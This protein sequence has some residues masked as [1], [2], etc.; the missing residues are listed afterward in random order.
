MSQ[1][2]D[3][4][5]LT[6]LQPYEDLSYNYTL[7]G[8]Q[9]GK[10]I[11]L[12]LGLDEFGL[13]REAMALKAFKGYGAISVIDHQKNAL[14]LQRAIPGTS[15]KGNPNA[16]EIACNVIKRLNKAPI[17]IHHRF[18]N[19]SEWLAVLDKPWKIPN[20]YLEKARKL[21]D[22]L[23]KSSSPQILLHGDLHQDNILSHDKDWLIIDPKGVIG[24]PINEIWVCVEDLSYDLKFI[25]T[26][27]DYSFDE[28]VK[29]YYVHL[30]LAACWQLED[31]LDPHLFLNLAHSV[32][33]MIKDV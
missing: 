25:S 11:V 13:E 27:F 4:W 2:A 21:K 16:I 12:K 14:L 3:L 5:G 18:P 24:F 22:Q 17:P 15:L 26:F 6:H 33:P 10:P 19:V 9:N 28:V 31:N 8:Y 29:W 7:F 23:L 32:R 30:I 1:L 20:D